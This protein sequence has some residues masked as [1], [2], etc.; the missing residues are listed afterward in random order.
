MRHKSHT[1]YSMW[2]EW[3]LMRVAGR[4]YEPRDVLVYTMDG[5]LTC[6]DICGPGTATGICW[7]GRAVFAT[8]FTVRT[9]HTV[10]KR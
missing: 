6:F 9:G 8:G 1:R 10:L 7:G 2:W 3:G 5:L 4:A